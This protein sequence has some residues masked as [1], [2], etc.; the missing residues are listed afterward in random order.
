M[1]LSSDFVHRTQMS[2]IEIN[3][4]LDKVLNAVSAMEARITVVEDK[5]DSRG[6][7]PT[8]SSTP[9]LPPKSPGIRESS[10][11]EEVRIYDMVDAAPALPYRK[12]GKTFSVKQLEY[13]SEELVEVKKYVDN[14]KSKHVDEKA[15]VQG[16]LNS[17]I[18][19][20]RPPTGK[21]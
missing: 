15:K 2:L 5:V 8:A 13:L 11:Y 20:L 21:S 12:R 1:A 4:K 17:L 6:S 14:I 7:K 3:D 19:T 10:R 16:S 18:A 9:A